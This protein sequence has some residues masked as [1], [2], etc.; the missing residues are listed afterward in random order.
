MEKKNSVLNVLLAGILFILLLAA[1]VLKALRPDLLLPKLN[2][3]AM[4]GILLTAL[5]LEQY[6]FVGRKRCCLWDT[7]LAA[8]S[9]G[10]LPWAAGMTE[11]GMIWKY[12]VIGGGVS[13]VTVFLFDS[14]TQRIRSGAAGRASLALTAFM[15]FLAGQC[16]AGVWL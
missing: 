10:V 4:L 7:L 1:A 3:P 13:F 8:V 12:A 14:I 2:I 15:L 16:F 5:C 9:F 6:F 11:A